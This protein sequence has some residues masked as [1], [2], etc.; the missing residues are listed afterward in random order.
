MNCFRAIFA[1]SGIM[2]V[3]LQNDVVNMLFSKRTRLFNKAPQ[4]TD[5]ARLISFACTRISLKFAVKSV[6]AA[7]K[8]YME[9][10]AAAKCKVP[11][12]RIL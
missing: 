7:P 5:L 10:A 9:F 11:V 1:R 3:V 12:D 2:F 4:P 6:I 8:A